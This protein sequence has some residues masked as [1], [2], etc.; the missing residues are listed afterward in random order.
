MYGMLPAALE[1]LLLFV[2]EVYV[3]Y[4]NWSCME[5]D[6]CQMIVKHWPYSLQS[7]LAKFIVLLMHFHNITDLS[8]M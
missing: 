2:P 7:Q 1:M 3:Q 6:Y 4:S 8:D 5:K